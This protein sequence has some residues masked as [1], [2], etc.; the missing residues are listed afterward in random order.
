MATKNQLEVKKYISPE[1]KKKM[2]SWEQGFITSLF[3]RELEWT[4]KQLEVWN[5]IK[6]KY[7][8]EERTVVER[9]IYLPTGYAAPEHQSIMTREMRK[10][11]GI[12]RNIKSK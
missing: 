1:I 11:L 9:I 6:K 7:K 5:N 3:K 12:Y 4:E 8:L 10:Q 2:T